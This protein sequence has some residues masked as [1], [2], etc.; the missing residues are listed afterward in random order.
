MLVRAAP[1]SNDFLL[2]LAIQKEWLCHRAPDGDFS[3]ETEVKEIV[4]RPIYAYI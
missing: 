2:N 4:Y 3:K 1:E